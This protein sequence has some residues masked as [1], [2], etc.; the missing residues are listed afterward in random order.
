MG[1][2]LVGLDSGEAGVVRVG[3]RSAVVVREV[4]GATPARR[5]SS[6]SDVVQP[7]VAP[8]SSAVPV[9]VTDS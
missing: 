1:A 9:A 3:S 8:S 4:D 5:S 7:T 6:A 2:F